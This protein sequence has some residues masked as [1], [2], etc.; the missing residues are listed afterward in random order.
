ME[1]E[2]ERNESL[3]DSPYSAFA[4]SDKE[5]M[6]DVRKAF[7]QSYKKSINSMVRNNMKGTPIRK[8]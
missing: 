8:E 4:L 7:D 2:K 5:L 1:R 6:A 3:K